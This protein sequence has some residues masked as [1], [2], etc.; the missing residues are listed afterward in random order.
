MAEDNHNENHR[1]IA[2]STSICSSL[3]VLEFNWPLFVYK[4]R[5]VS[6]TEDLYTIAVWK[7][8]TLL[9]I[10]HLQPFQTALAALGQALITAVRSHSASTASASSDRNVLN[11]SCHAEA[12]A[13]A[14]SF[15]TTDNNGQP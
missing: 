2:G 11:S 1:K 13:G 4:R 14:K 10:C 12:S 5:M 9:P 7:G 3:E 15:S 8:T 6:G